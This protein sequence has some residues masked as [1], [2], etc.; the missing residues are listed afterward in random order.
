MKP[1]SLYDRIVDVMEELVRFTVLLRRHAD[2]LV[3]RYSE[4]KE[5]KRDIDP[6]ADISSIALSSS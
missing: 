3:D 6:K 4:R 1:S 5:A 2:Q